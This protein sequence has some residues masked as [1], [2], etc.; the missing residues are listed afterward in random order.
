[1]MLFSPFFGVVRLLP[2]LPWASIK[3]CCL[4]V[5][6]CTPPVL[7]CLATDAK[8]MMSYY[9]SLL[10]GHSPLI[11]LFWVSIANSDLKERIWADKMLQ[12]S[13]ARSRNEVMQLMQKAAEASGGAFVMGNDS[14]KKIY[15]CVITWLHSIWVLVKFQ[16]KHTAVVTALKVLRVSNCCSIYW[17]WKNCIKSC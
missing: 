2:G 7:L 10:K 11:K 1:M 8:L 9:W 13:L 3:R 6:K 5:A 15:W 16:S 12:V 14:S 17:I 4:L